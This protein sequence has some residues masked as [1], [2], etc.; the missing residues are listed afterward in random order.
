MATKPATA[1]SKKGKTGKRA[2]HYQLCRSGITMSFGRSIF[3]TAAICLRWRTRR[4]PELHPPRGRASSAH[5]GQHHGVTGFRSP[6][7]FIF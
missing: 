1:R 2:A 5:A 6:P 7:S 3:V 4:K